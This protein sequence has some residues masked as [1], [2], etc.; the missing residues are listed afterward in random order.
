[1]KTTDIHTLL[2]RAAD[3]GRCR[4]VKQA[5]AC[6]ASLICLLHAAQGAAVTN[7]ITRI[8]EV[9]ALT[10]EDIRQGRAVRLRGVVTARLC[11]Q[12]IMQDGDS[13][14]FVYPRLARDEGVW[15][16]DDDVFGSLCPGTEVEITGVPAGQAFATV[17]TAA[18]GL[19]TLE[20]R[21]AGMLILAR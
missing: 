15:K 6:L 13:G 11:R 5:F 12:F 14:I 8:G 10:G 17:V 21:Y 7:A 3:G 4:A 9:K 16:G 2:P 1:M 18:N 20:V 19:V